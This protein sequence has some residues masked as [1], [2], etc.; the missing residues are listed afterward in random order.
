MIDIRTRTVTS[1]P[2]AAN[3]SSSVKNGLRFWGYGAVPI[4]VTLFGVARFY[5]K[6]QRKRLLQ[7]MQYAE[8]S[9]RKEKRSE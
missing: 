4:I 6:T 7:A 1:R 8:K 5:L 9:A 2:L 3:L